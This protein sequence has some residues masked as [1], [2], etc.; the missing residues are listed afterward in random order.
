MGVFKSRQDYKVCFTVGW[1]AFLSIE[2]LSRDWSWSIK[3]IKF[4]DFN[5]III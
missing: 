5:F 1:R 2:N 3:K 4:T